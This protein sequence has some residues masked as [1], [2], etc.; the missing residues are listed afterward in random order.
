MEGSGGP[1]GRV[2]RR[3][4]K[5][6]VVTYLEVR[7]FID[8]AFEAKPYF[9]VGKALD[10]ECS[11]VTDMTKVVAKNDMLRFMGS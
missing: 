7:Y 1:S 9:R 6:L 8:V 11:K 3:W 10:L 2:A 4:P 5:S